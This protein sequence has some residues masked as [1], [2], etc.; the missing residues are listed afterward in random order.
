MCEVES[1]FTVQMDTGIAIST[2]H[3][4]AKVTFRCEMSIKKGKSVFFFVLL[5]FFYGTV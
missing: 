2:V 4:Q 3:W 1:L 5:S